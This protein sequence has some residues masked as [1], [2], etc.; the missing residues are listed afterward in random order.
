MTPRKKFKELRKLKN[1]SKTMQ[2]K[3][4]SPKKD[5]ITL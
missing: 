4:I 5:K 2:P 1:A 3:D